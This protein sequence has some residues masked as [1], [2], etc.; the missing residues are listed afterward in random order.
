M[1]IVESYMPEAERLRTTLEAEGHRISMAFNSHDAL[2]MLKSEKFH[3][4]IVAADWPDETGL[5]LLRHIRL[6]RS[7]R[8]SVVV[9]VHTAPTDEQLAS[10]FKY[11]SDV[12]LIKPIKQDDL[13]AFVR[14]IARATPESWDEDRTVYWNSQWD[15]ERDIT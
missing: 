11:C 1:L 10:C 12:N 3:F 15:A 4:V 7:T 5:Q 13:I 2:H 9:V 8:Q 6:N 14:R